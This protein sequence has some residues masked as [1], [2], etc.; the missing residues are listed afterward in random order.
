MDVWL[1]RKIQVIAVDFARAA[2]R[3]PFLHKDIW[4]V[5]SISRCQTNPNLRSVSS[6]LVFLASRYTAQYFA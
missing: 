6:V 5:L 1:T 4:S 3:S 2:T